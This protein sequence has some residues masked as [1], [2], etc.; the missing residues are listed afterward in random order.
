MGI[1]KMFKFGIYS[2]DQLRKRKSF[3]TFFGGSKNVSITLYDKLIN[4]EDEKIAEYILNGFADDRGA[5]KRTYSK[6]FEA[7]DKKVIELIGSYFSKR[8]P[9]FVHDVAV[10]DGRTSCDFFEKLADIFPKVNFYASDY[11]SE[12]IVLESGTTKVTINTHGKVLEVV[13][14]PFV[15]NA[16]KRSS[17]HYYFLHN[18]L[19]FLVKHSI[20]K[21]ILRQHEM[22]SLH[23][24]T[25]KLFCPKARMLEQSDK[26]FHLG[27]Y[28]VLEPFAARDKVSVVRAMNILNASYF[29]TEEFNILLGYFWD[30][31]C[32]GG[33][34]I[35]GSNQDA[36][37]VV[38]G[39]I[40]EKKANH[41]QKIWESGSG[42]W[43]D[44]IIISFEK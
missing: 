35:A 38:D 17:Y 4:P 27:K 21:R 10:S 34:L 1:L 42:L 25:I 23:G 16:I 41:F 14:P 36:D 2:L 7:F 43:L 5:Y 12:V 13:W 11:D 20:V 28:N 24:R 31:L 32:E 29:T 9:L 8:N 15:F 19:F 30:S 40:Y 26:R 39:A 3:K 33:L 18:I 6:R 44:K 37:T 22:G